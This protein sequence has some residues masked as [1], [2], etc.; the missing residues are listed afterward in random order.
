MPIQAANPFGTFLEGRRARQDEQYGQTRN[1]LAQM[2]VEQA[3]RD[4]ANRNALAARQQEQ[5]SQDQVARSLEQTAA[6]AMRIAQSPNPR[7]ELQA[8]REFAA[9]LMKQHPELAQMGDDELKQYMGWVAGEA[10]SKL[11][12]APV[13]PKSPE[14]F[15]LGAGQTRYGPDGKLIASAPQKAE[16]FTL[17]PG[18][19]RY[20]PDGK[21]IASRPAAQKDPTPSFQHVVLENGNIG[22]F[23]SRTGRIADTGQKAPPN[24]GNENRTFGRADKLR[25]EYN[26]ASKEFVTVGDSYVRVTEAAK[27]PSA[28]GDLSMIFSYMKMLDPNSV[29]REQEFANAQNAAGVPDRV[30]AAWNKLL[31]GERLAPAQRA[32]FLKQANK[33]YT[34]Q[35]GRHEATVKK[36]YTDIAKRWNI[37]PNDV[38]GDLDVGLPQASSEQSPP[39]GG[40]QPGAVEDGYRFKGGNPADP[41]SWEK[42]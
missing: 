23:D 28:A 19:M 30:R 5:Y 40:P 10:Q 11:G 42:M 9:N 39:S 29:V 41:N 18:D 22:A 3:P 12:I 34:G 27:D 26:S 15:T 25:D 4:I 35:K 38:V 13:Q 7:G 6:A 14:A 33:L 32:D 17:G 8:N 20:G 31:R 16:S 21:P 36:R 1:A 37:D 24:P 2:E